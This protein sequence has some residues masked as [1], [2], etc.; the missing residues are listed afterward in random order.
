MTRSSYSAGGG[1]KAGEYERPSSGATIHT[2][3]SSVC[4]H[5]WLKKP[6]II[7]SGAFD[8]KRYKFLSV[9]RTQIRARQ[10]TIEEYQNRKMQLLQDNLAFKEQIESS[11]VDVHDQVKGLLQ[12]YDKFRGALDTLNK[13]YEEDLI[14]AKKSLKSTQL[15]VNM[16]LEELQQNLNA[17]NVKLQKEI[18]KTNTLLNYKDK[19]YPEKALQIAKLKKRKEIIASAFKEELEELQAVIETET[20]KFGDHTQRTQEEIKVKAVQDMVKCINPSVQELA[21]QNMA[22]KKEI[23][24]HLNEV[25]LLED[26]NQGLEEKIQSLLESKELNTREQL[27]PDVVG[28][29]VK[30]TPD[31]DLVLDIPTH[32]WLPI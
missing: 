14:A 6:V 21:L 11:E 3:C 18:Q 16:E 2:Q 26:K 23:E 13:T 5:P 15:K 12:K 27:F 7:P 10:R 28:E 32:K 17:L 22:M 30:C 8:K 24:M 1:S 19:E 4:L 25:K 31:M 29:R 20:V 9:L